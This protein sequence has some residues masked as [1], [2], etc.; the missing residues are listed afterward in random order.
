MNNRSF[1]TTIVL[2]IALVV[3]SCNQL[4]EIE[5]QNATQSMGVTPSN[6]TIYI[7][8]TFRTESEGWATPPNGQMRFQFDKGA[9]PSAKS[10]S[11]M[12]NLWAD[13]ENTTCSVRL[14]NHTDN[15]VVANSELS[16][17][18]GGAKIQKKISGDLWPDLPNKKV[19]LGLQV[20]STKPGSYVN[21]SNAAFSLG[22]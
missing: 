1:S 21:A 10:A 7:E 8:G 6:N 13:N 3:F 18:Q 9:Y 20:R 12:V 15:K 16:S 19:E 14:F 5:P 22:F 4:P 2:L 17:E 11:L